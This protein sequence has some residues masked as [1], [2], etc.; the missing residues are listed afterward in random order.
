[1][2]AIEELLLAA[3]R[4]AESVDDFFEIERY[5]PPSRSDY[6]KGDAGTEEFCAAREHHQLRDRIAA[7]EGYSLALE[8]ELHRRF[9]AV[10]DTAREAKLEVTRCP[11]CNRPREPPT[12][13]LE[14]YGCS[15]VCRVCDGHWTLTPISFFDPSPAHG[16]ARARIPRLAIR[17]AHRLR[18]PTQPL[19]KRALA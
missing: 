1:M 13:A 19:L 6:E 16:G 10:A 11:R 8:R 17:P 18:T 9:Q 5:P 3:E 4:L 15:L 12:V 7:V 2:I 14:G